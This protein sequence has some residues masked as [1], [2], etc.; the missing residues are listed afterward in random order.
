[1]LSL[2][3]ALTTL[4]KNAHLLFSVGVVLPMLWILGAAIAPIAHAEVRLGAD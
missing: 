1:M 3:L 2:T 4:R